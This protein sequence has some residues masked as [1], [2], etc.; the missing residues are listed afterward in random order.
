MDAPF[1]PASDDSQMAVVSE[2]VVV[3]FPIADV[4]DFLVDGT[5]NA[6]WRPEV[7]SVIFAAGPAQSA[8]WAQS[9][10]DRRGRI[11][12]ADYRVTWY[13]H[14]GSLELTVVNGPSRPT[15][16]FALKSFGPSSTEVHYTVDVKPLLWPF[17]RTRFGAPAAQAEAANILN[18]PKA[19]GSARGVSVR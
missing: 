11:R 5:H 18:L 8:V 13:E 17:D 16:T 3:P 6:L 7:V 1:S 15:T 14:P 9:V 12:R 2:T 10:R 4:F 19:M